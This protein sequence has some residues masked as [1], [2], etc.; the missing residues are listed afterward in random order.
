MAERPLQVLLLEDNA[1]DAELIARE[2]T[3]AGIPH[4]AQRVDTEPTFVRA[5][6]TAAPDVILSD[7]SLAAFD[8]IAALKAVRAHR[9]GTPVIIVTGALA[10]RESIAIES[11]KAGADDLILKDRLVRLGPAVEA[12][13]AARRPLRTLSPRQ[14]E[15][16]RLITLGHST[17]DIARRLKVGVKT[18]ETHRAAVMKRLNIHDVAGLVRFAVRLGLISPEP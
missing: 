5:L 8:A 7:H 9:P 1:A 13:L 10:P 18:V 11:L 14:L 12:A 3:R 4:T 17:R 2:L 15:V 16:L 6:K